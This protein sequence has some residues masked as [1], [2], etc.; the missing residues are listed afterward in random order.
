MNIFLLMRFFLG[1]LAS[2]DI[3]EYGS[4]CS[5]SAIFMV[6]IA[7]HLFPDIKVYALDTFEGMP[8]TDKNVDAHNVGDF[9]DTNMEELAQHIKKLG[10]KNFVLVK[11]LFEDTK[12]DVMKKASQNSLAHIDCDI[13]PAVRFSYDGVKRYMV[14]GGYIVLDDAIVSSCIGATEVV[15]DLMIRRDGLNSEQ[16]WPHFLFRI[17]K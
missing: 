13:T 15:E 1:R 12:A 17:N 16:I 10:L 9:K 5:G 3:V 11:G 8:E 7:K 6:Y 4:Y 14:N 2:G